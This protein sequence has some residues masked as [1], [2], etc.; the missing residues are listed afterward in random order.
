MPTSTPNINYT[1]DI[2]FICAT[3]MIEV[4]D[5]DIAYFEHGEQLPLGPSFQELV[6]CFENKM[7]GKP[8]KHDGARSLLKQLE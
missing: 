8:T 2:E 1:F 5:V 4:L 7:N 3:R 6:S